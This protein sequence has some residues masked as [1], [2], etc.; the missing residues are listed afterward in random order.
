MIIT[1]FPT[2]WCVKATFLNH[3]TMLGGF[4]LSVHVETDGKIFNVI[5][6]RADTVS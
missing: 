4:M 6:T 1:V 2:K 3:H 5:V